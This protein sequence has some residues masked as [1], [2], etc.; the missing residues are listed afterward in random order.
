MST[1]SKTF[2]FG[3]LDACAEVG[4]LGDLAS[5]SVMVRLGKGSTLAS[6]EIAQGTG[7]QLLQAS[8]SKRSYAQGA[9]ASLARREDQ[10]SA[11]ELAHVD[12]LQSVFEP[13]LRL[14]PSACVNLHVQVLEEDA[15]VDTKLAAALA[16]SLC[17]SLTGLVQGSPK[18]LVQL[19]VIDGLWK[20]N[21]NQDL[22][23]SAQANLWVLGDT[24]HLRY[25][26]GSARELDEKLLIKALEAAHGCIR[27]VSEVL[28]DFSNLG[29]PEQNVPLRNGLPTSALY[30]R[31][32]ALATRPLLEI[33]SLQDAEE[34]KGKW[35]DLHKAIQISFCLNEDKPDH[36]AKITSCFRQVTTEVVRARILNGAPR[37]DQRGAAQIRT[38]SKIEVGSHRRAHGSACMTMPGSI[39]HATSMVGLN[40][41]ALD[42]LPGASAEVFAAHVYL[43]AQDS[44]A[45][46]AAEDTSRWLTHALRPVL[47]SAGRFPY[48]LRLDCEYWGAPS[49]SRQDALCA[50]TLALMDAG[51]PIK[52]PVAAVE[53]GLICSPS[54]CKTLSELDDIERPA[55][56]LIAVL[57]GSQAGLTGIHLR[58]HGVRLTAEILTVV[59]QQARQNRLELLLRMS[60]ALAAPRTLNPQ[61]PRVKIMKISPRQTGLL[62]GRGGTTVRALCESTSSQIEVFPDGRVLVS[63]HND[64]CLQ[65][66]IAAIEITLQP[67]RTGQVYQGIVSGFTEHGALITLAPGRSGLLPTSAT[68]SPHSRPEKQFKVGESV[69]TLCTDL[70]NR[71]RIWLSV[72]ALSEQEEINDRSD[73]GPLSLA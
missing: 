9:M 51:V 5:Y 61:V 49:N 20:I 56:D 21:P 8:F 71:G 30:Q 60:D 64:L 12:F 7:P 52:A 3:Q 70:D 62:V 15:R 67:I 72:K 27:K 69:R 11:T 50:A 25:V 19:A 68:L 14:A 47:P 53:I 65:Q 22:I 18:V 54:H 17:L 16:A 63:A 34:R 44:R 1:S 24:E 40:R 39:A 38:R 46:A 4:W 6:C 28:A 73:S 45:I 13:V 31:V 48:T 10:P 35:R 36:L 66:A 57:A 2:S 33:L 37:P 59:L 29:K 41:S 32:R 58:S 23:P 55:C 43:H 42:K 26:D